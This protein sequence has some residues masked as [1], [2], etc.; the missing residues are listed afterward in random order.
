MAFL[1]PQTNAQL[2]PAVGHVFK[3]PGISEN[4]GLLSL[5]ATYFP[6]KV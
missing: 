3:K 1:P 4:A 5:E 6:A 2:N